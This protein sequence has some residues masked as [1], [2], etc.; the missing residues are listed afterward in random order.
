MPLNWRGELLESWPRM[1]EGVGMF[2]RYVLVGI[3][4]FWGAGLGAQVEAEFSVLRVDSSGPED[5]GLAA[6][7]KP[8]REGVEAFSAEVIGYA[9]EPLSRSRPE[10]GLSNLVADSLRVVGEREFESE[11]DLAVTNFGGL[12]RNLPKGPLTMGLITEL[13]PFDNYIVLLEVRGELVLELA[14][15]IASGSASAISGLKVVGSKSGELLSAEIG[16]E[17]VVPDGTYRLVTIDYLLANWTSLFREEWIVSRK[18]SV[19]LRQREAIVLHLSELTRKGIK[20]YDAAEG[21]V[22]VVSGD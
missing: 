3:V 22:R 8:Y 10:C 17:S 18:V 9:A 19:N 11:V 1:V 15:N 13:S 21:R 4:S 5:P 20:V 6:Y 14:R 7:I 12:R 16:G 2:W